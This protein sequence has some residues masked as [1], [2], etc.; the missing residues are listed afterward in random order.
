M[1]C[2][3][4]CHA[5]AVLGAYA[6]DVSDVDL[7]NAVLKREQCRGLALHLVVNLL[8]PYSAAAQPM[9]GAVAQ[10]QGSHY[11]SVRLMIVA[12]FAV[13]VAHLV[14]A[15]VCAASAACLAF[16]V[17]VAA[18]VAG[19]LCFL[20]YG[21]GATRLGAA[22]AVA[23]SAR[24]RFVRHRRPGLHGDVEEVVMEAEMTPAPTVKGAA[25]VT[26]EPPLPR[27]RVG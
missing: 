6:P 18:R 9:A 15:A 5:A 2:V 21:A 13:S 24:G 19:L 22:A 20:M 7:D 11:G 1:Y 16:V 12:E 4:L 23:A 10:A 3:G 14:P 27:V 25:T 17:E 8:A 26:A